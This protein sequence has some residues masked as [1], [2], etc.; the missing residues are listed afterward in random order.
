MRPLQ[1]L[2][3]V[4]VEQ[5]VAGPFCTLRLAQAGARVIK[6]ER[7]EGDPARAYDDV[8]AGD[9]SYFAWLNQG[10]E[11]VTLDFK[12]PDGAAL[13]HAML[14][15]ADVMVQ[16]HAPGALDRAG[17][18]HD[19][20]SAVNPRL[21]RCDISGYGAGP[22]VGGK[23]AY[24]LLVQA[25][26][27]L[28]AV[29]G[30]PGAPGRIGVSICDIGA[31]MTAH[32][33]VLEA[34]IRRGITG[35]GAQVGVSLFDVAAEWMTVPYLHARHGAGAPVPVG[36]QHPSIAPYGAFPTADG[37]SVLI[38]VQNEREW[39]RLCTMF[40]QPGW[41]DAPEYRSNV[42]R[43]QHR[44][45][46]DRAIAELTGRSTADALQA[47]LEAVQIACGRLNGPDDLAR[48]PAL[49]LA[50][51]CASTGGVLQ[52]PA[53]P[54]TWAGAESAGLGCAPGLGEHGAAIA[55]EFL[56]ERAR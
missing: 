54:V 20:V 31:G 56:G 55:L 10:K 17:F 24:D 13:L 26:S 52:S 16:N 14:A 30:V 9:S 11:S 41:A 40:G 48:H 47:R 37:K 2:L 33:A 27:G 18:G 43:V 46:L 4:A 45:A 15:R 36:L 34:L 1:G 53:A 19:I 8:A 22:A 6:V 51:I 42:A 25:E 35:A 29:S 5:A 12:Q 50:G 32:A 49:R 21:I 7:A 38:A 44:G 39:Q 28:I 3:V 23:R